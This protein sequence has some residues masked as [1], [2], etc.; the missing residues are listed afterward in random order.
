MRDGQIV[1]GREW[2]ITVT[3]GKGGKEVGTLLLDG[4]Q[5]PDVT[6]FNDTIMTVLQLPLAFSLYWKLCTLP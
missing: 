6:L 4:S 2:I 5:V 1:G 3:G